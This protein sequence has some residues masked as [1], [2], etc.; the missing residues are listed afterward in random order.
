MKHK[1]IGKVVSGNSKVAT[2]VTVFGEKN[3]E[4]KI[5]NVNELFRIIKSG[6][7]KIAE[8]IKKVPKNWIESRD[9]GGHTLTHWLAKRGDVHLLELVIDH[10]APIDEASSDDVGMH[11]LHWACTEGRLGCARLLAKRGADLDARDLQGCT[12]LIIAS[13]WGQA[14][15]VAFLIKMGAT[16]QILDKNKDS[17]LHWASY[18]GNLEIVGLL[19]HLGLPLDEPDA[20]GQTPLHL[21]ALCGNLNVCEYLLLDLRFP[22][23]LEPLDKNKK[24]PK[25]LALEKGHKKL[26][27]FL[28]AQRPLCQQSLWTFIKHRLTFKACIYWLLG[29]SNPDGMRWPL[30]IMIFN[31]LLAHFFYFFYFLPFFYETPLLPINTEQNLNISVNESQKKKACTRNI[32]RNE[33]SHSIFSMDLFYLCVAIRSWYTR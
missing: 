31:K 29:E 25:D 7:G 1:V 32:A 27:Y 21:A 30:L 17:A 20:Y 10:G 4:E 9:E 16:A 23:P 26:A 11:P 33:F 5:E 3:E 8:I 19:H 24:S 2:N 18:K 12:P 14:D 28:D 15:M 13:Q 6:D 22:V